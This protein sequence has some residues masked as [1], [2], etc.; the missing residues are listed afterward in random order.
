M[1]SHFLQCRK[2]WR[3]YALG[4]KYDQKT[5]K[6][7]WFNVS[8]ILH[9]RQKQCGDSLYQSIY[10]RISLNHKLSY[11][12]EDVIWI[13]QIHTHFQECFDR[14]FCDF[15]LLK[16]NNWYLKTVLRKTVTC[17]GVREAGWILVLALMV[18]SKMISPRSLLNSFQKSLLNDSVCVFCK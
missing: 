6:M 3:K 1:S 9:K 15:S 13:C 18:L 7:L 11:C 10:H 12:P 2:D 4:R 5:S 14:V 17:K 16:C 8:K